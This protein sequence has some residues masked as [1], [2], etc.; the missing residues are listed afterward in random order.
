M[1]ELSSALDARR[2]LSLR[3][4]SLSVLLGNAIGFKF[5]SLP[6]FDFGHDLFGRRRLVHRGSL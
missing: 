3:S 6:T 2:T 4:L 1:E 5:G